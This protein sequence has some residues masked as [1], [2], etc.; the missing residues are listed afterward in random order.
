MA[1]ILSWRKVPGPFRFEILKQDPATQTM[2]VLDRNTRTVYTLQAA[3]K[4]EF[5]TMLNMDDARW[6][7]FTKTVKG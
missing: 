7:A 5:E 2:D 4:A 3:G 1:R 6:A